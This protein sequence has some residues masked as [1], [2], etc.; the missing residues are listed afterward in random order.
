MKEKTYQVASHF[1]DGY[2]YRSCLTLKGI[3]NRGLE[4]FFSNLQKISPMLCFGLRPGM[5]SVFGFAV[6]DGRKDN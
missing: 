6:R 5:K 4:A 2:H 3:K 1:S